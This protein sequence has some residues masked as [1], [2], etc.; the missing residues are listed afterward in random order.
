MLV[1]KVTVLTYILTVFAVKILQHC[2]LVPNVMFLSSGL[3]NFEKLKG[4]KASRCLLDQRTA[5]LIFL[6]NEAGRLQV[7]CSLQ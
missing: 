1:R 7:E 3:L 4:H 5:L 6:I 2:I